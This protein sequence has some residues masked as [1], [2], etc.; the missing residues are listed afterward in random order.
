MINYRKIFIKS[1]VLGWLFATAL[2]MMLMSSCSTNRNV[3][4][5]RSKMILLTNTNNGGNNHE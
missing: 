5:E 3:M 2:Y 1:L 4:V